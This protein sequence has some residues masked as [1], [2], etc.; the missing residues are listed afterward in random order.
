MDPENI[1]KGGILIGYDVNGGPL[2]PDSPDQDI[3]AP[4]GKVLL[5]KK[6]SNAFTETPKP[7][8]T[9]KDLLIQKLIKTK[10][11]MIPE[12]VVIPLE[13]KTKVDLSEWLIKSG[14]DRR[15]QEYWDIYK[16]ISPEFPPALTVGELLGDIMGN[17]DPGTPALPPNVT[18]KIQLSDWICRSLKVKRGSEH[19]DRLYKL[20]RETLEDGY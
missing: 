3:Y 12:G 15:D 16:L 2:F 5:V 18:T 4:G 14:F 8:V 20:Y 10:K 11:S 6:G 17:T 1:K 7:D 13:V 9:V 19:Y